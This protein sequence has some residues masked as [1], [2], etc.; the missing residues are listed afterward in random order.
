MTGVLLILWSILKEHIICI[1]C[2]SQTATTGQC[3]ETL[4]FVRLL[5][6]GGVRLRKILTTLPV[7]AGAAG[8]L[9]AS[10]CSPYISIDGAYITRSSGQASSLAPSSLFHCSLTANSFFC[11]Y[12]AKTVIQINLAVT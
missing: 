2:R 5:G 9:G 4:S 7:L 6:A 10:Y 12:A 11:L 3:A 1:H 8:A